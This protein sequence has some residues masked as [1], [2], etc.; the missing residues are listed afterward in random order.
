[1]EL[2]IQTCSSCALGA[3]VLH[4]IAELGDLL[5]L[6]CKISHI[7]AHRLRYDYRA[8]SGEDKEALL[9]YLTISIV[10]LAGSSDALFASILFYVTG[11]G[12]ERRKTVIKSE[13]PMGKSRRSRVVPKRAFP[14][15]KN[16][17]STGSDHRRVEG[18]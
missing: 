13:R 15:V 4:L 12:T 9:T 7:G 17:R 11:V 3:H 16:S 14:G 1:M 8:V 2:Q 6:K 10:Y 18:Q 5:F